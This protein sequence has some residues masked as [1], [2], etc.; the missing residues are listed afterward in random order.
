MG[1]YAAVI[2]RDDWDKLRQAAA[3][4]GLLIDSRSDP[5]ELPS[6]VK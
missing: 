1:D 4:L 3:A 5:G 6:D 2:R